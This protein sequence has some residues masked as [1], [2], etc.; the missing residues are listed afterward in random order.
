MLIMAIAF[1]FDVNAWMPPDERVNASELPKTFMPLQFLRRSAVSTSRELLLRLVAGKHFVLLKPNPPNAIARPGRAANDYHYL[2]GNR[3][4]A[5]GLC[6][7]VL[8][9]IEVCQAPSCY[10]YDCERLC[11]VNLL[12]VMCKPTK[13]NRFWV[14]GHFSVQKQGMPIS[15]RP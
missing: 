6:A 9:S 15:F 12:Y 8:F 7:S 5:T 11:T 4:V 10:G 2:E 1:D 3:D 13:L 14:A